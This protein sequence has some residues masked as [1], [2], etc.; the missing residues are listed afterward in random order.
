M[1][2]ITIKQFLSIILIFILITLDK[3]LGIPFLSLLIL[4]V[5]AKNWPGL[6]RIGLIVFSAIVISALFLLPVSLTMIFLAMITYGWI[7]AGQIP[8]RANLIRVLWIGSWSVVY[9]FFSGSG[10]TTWPLIF[11]CIAMILT[12]KYLEKTSYGN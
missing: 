3:T 1:L 10:E 11:T 9:Y 6:A 2:A 5:V 12:W 7:F 8:A 4:S